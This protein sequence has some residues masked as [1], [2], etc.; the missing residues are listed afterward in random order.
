MVNL[1]HNKL[2]YY[3]YSNNTEICLGRICFLYFYLV[4]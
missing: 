1:K 3:L 4:N 2:F